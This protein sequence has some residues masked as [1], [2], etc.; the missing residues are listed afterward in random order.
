MSRVFFTF[1]PG[2]NRIEDK[3]AENYYTVAR[4]FI[5][6]QYIKLLSKKPTNQA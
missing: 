2:K 4:F 3:T 6:S 1:S 5:N